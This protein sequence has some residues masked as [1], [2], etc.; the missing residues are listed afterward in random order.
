MSFDEPKK[1]ENIS[2]RFEMVR[3]FGSNR[4]ISRILKNNTRIRAKEGEEA[5]TTNVLGKDYDTERC[6]FGGNG[7]RDFSP[8]A[9]TVEISIDSQ[10]GRILNVV[11][12]PPY[13][14]LVS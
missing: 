5:R 1:R 12:A 11:S 9:R 2:V 14:T 4:G 6:L 8:S 13:L 7:Y 3:R 10:L